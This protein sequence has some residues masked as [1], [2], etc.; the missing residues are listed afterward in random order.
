M[1]GIARESCYCF[2]IGC[3]TIFSNGVYA[4]IY[5]SHCTTQCQICSFSIDV[6]AVWII[7]DYKLVQS[8]SVPLDV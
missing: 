8:Y 5:G 3:A 6:F 4:I 2:E 1:E 7:T